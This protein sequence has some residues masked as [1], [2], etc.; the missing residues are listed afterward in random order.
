MESTI[1]K[2]KVIFVDRL[3]RFDLSKLLFLFF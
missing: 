2:Q 3:G 1:G